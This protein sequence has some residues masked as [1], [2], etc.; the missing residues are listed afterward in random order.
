MNNEW[1]SI[2]DKLPSPNQLVL[3]YGICEREVLSS[4]KEYSIGIVEWNVPMASDCKDIDAY[5]VWYT[6]ITHWQ[7]LPQKPI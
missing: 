5:S 4:D 2:N 1:I 3:V 6:N 7:Y